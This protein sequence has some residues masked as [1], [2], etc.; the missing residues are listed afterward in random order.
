MFDYYN[1]TV[2]LLAVSLMVQSAEYLFIF[3]NRPTKWLFILNMIVCVLFLSL[4]PSYLLFVPFGVAFFIFYRV[5]G[6]FNGGSDHMTMIVLSMCVLGS[7][8]LTSQWIAS[9]GLWFIGIQVVLSYFVSGI[10][11]LKNS[12]WLD[13][14]ALRLF[15]TE[16]NYAIPNLV[17]SWVKN[18]RLMLVASWSVIAF[19]CTFPLALF[20]F[21]ILCA[22]LGLAFL[23]HLVNFAVLGLNRFVFAWLA[24]YPAV[25]FISQNFLKK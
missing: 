25:L 2:R 17:I 23:F 18:S 3:K 19:E 15:L 6:L 22:Y 7:S 12:S 20:N 10:A 14:S 8:L 5:K 16:S 1:W 13:G 24:A 21:N 4:G 9:F 11:K